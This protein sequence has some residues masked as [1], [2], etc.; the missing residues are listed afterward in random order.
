MKTKILFV[1]IGMLLF[2]SFVLAVAPTIPSTLSPDNNSVWFNDPTLTC[3]GSTDADG[4][5]INY[6]FHG[7]NIGLTGFSFSVSSDGRGLTTDGTYLYLN[8]L[9]DNKVYVYDYEGNSIRNFNTYSDTRG[10]T[11]YGDDLYVV[12][13]NNDRVYNYNKTGTENSSKNFDLVNPSNDHPSG[14]TTDGNYFYVVDYSDDKVYTYYFNG[15]S[16]GQ[17]WNLY[18]VNTNP[19]GITTNGEYILITDT[20]DD[21]VYK[22]EMDGTFIDYNPIS[23]P[24][25]PT[26]DGIA[27][28]GYY[29]WIPDR[30]S[31]KIYQYYT[32]QLLQNSLLTTYD[33]DDIDVG[34][35]HHWYCRACDNNSDCSNFTE[36]RGLYKMNFTNCSS[37]NFALNFTGKDEETGNDLDDIDFDAA[38]T[39][40]SAWD[41]LLY[42]FGLSGDNNYSLCLDPA[43]IDVNLTG[44]VEY[45]STN[46]SYSFPRQYYFYDAI[47]NGDS[48]TSIDLFQLDDEFA[49]P[50]TFTAIRGASTIEDVIIHVQRYDPGTGIYT[51]SAMGETNNNGQD[52]IYLRM[53]DAWYRILAYEDG[54]LVFTGDP[55]HILDSTYTIQLTGG[56]DGMSDYWDNWN[57]LDSINYNLNWNESGN[58]Y[59]SLTAD[60]GSGVSTAMCLKVEKWSM[61]EGM[62]ELYYNCESSASV[63]MSYEITDFDAFYNAK[64]I[65]YFDGGW[66]L[67]DTEEVSLSSNLSNLIGKDGIIYALLLIG[68]LAFI[69]LWNPVAAVILTMFGL[70]VA[71]MIGLISVPWVALIGI[72]IAGGII[73]FKIRE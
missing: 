46:S 38:F 22:Y 48:T 15:T 17:S 70:I 50:I 45:D 9:N 55:E 21:Y 57:S 60:D 44:F 25:S 28:Y 2:S 59:I 43:G 31:N 20:G 42:N 47:I 14:I 16:T 58:N 72:L 49:S 23:L 4:D 1:L 37:G 3:S 5:D 54:V 11:T 27:I 35:N 68:I 6:S 67:L 32:H 56:M 61:L 64:F 36:T 12:D 30:T 63:T 18:N 41:A 66:R 62:E 39:L 7:G 52:I 10:I 51:L 26:P 19:G 65:A 73:L 69:G 33:W 24:G 13:L 53:T 8:D 40:E 71:F 34:L 29:F